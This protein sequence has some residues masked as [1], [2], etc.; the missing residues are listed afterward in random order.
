MQGKNGY[1]VIAAFVFLFLPGQTIAQEDHPKSA[2][3]WHGYMGA[4]FRF[5]HDDAL[6]K[7]QKSKYFSAI[8]KPEAF[9]ESKN[10]RH[11]IHFIG[12]ARLDQHDHKRTHVDIRDLY[13]RYFKTNWEFS[14]GVKTV[15][16]GKTESNHL[17]DIINQYDL[18]EGRASENKLGQP[19]LQFVYAPEWITFEILATT[20]SRDIQFP[21]I[22]GRLQPGLTAGKPTFEKENA[23]YLP[24]AALRVAKNAGNF[25]VALSNFYGTNRLPVFNFLDNTYIPYYEEI[26]QTGLELQLLTNSFVWKG[27]FVNVISHR[28]TIQAFTIG[29]EYNLSLRSGQELKWMLE[30]TYDERGEEQ[31]SGINNDLFAGVNLNFNDRQSSNV[32]VSGFY[33]F[34]FETTLL[35]AQAKRRVGGAWMVKVA[36]TG[37]LKTAE[38]DFYHLIRNDSYLELGILN[39]F[40]K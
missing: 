12:F 30:Y 11:Q 14:V 20:Y 33:D 7:D 17:I 39:Y 25:E 22:H 6:Y 24:D 34:D 18:L 2:L 36:Y 38:G 29:C 19:M 35:R 31:I 21:G 28:R 4:D 13:W 15:A 10:A 1:L 27:E 26:N 40:S 9:F 5:F 23:R 8:F 32:S 16:W 3:D 37:I